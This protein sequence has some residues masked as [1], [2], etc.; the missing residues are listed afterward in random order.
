MNQLFKE[1]EAGAVEKEKMEF[2]DDNYLRLVFHI[3]QIL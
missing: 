3:I 2:L 1:E